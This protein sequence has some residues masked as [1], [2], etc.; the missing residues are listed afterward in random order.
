MRRVKLASNANHLFLRVES[1][2][3]RII[4]HTTRDKY[5]A[6]PWTRFGTGLLLQKF[7]RVQDSRLLT[8]RTKLSK[9]VHHLEN[10]AERARSRKSLDNENTFAACD[11]R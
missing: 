6:D 1:T 7:P 5:H 9:I 4:Y 3:M 2:D 8:H 10:L 11:P